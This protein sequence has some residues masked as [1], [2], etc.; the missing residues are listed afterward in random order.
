MKSSIILVLVL[1]LF[2]KPSFSQ[3]DKVLSFSLEDCI[4]KALKEN[5]T[6]AVEV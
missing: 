2:F 6:E 3:E 4:F 1:T 5:L